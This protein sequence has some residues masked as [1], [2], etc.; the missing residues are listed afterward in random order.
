MQPL[1]FPKVRIWYLITLTGIS[2]I[3]VAMTPVGPEEVASL[4]VIIL[5]LIF[6]I[7]T[8][9]EK[10]ITTSEAR[11]K[12][13]ET[14]FV[15]V[16]LKA[17][18][19]RLEKRGEIYLDSEVDFNDPNNFATVINR[20]GADEYRRMGIADPAEHFRG[21]RIRVRGTVSVKDNVP[22]IEVKDP[23]QIEIVTEN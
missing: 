6:S 8:T 16:I 5:G 22:R 21:K 20:E 3:C 1:I 10:P 18:K 13:N 17:T 19:N 7:A 23:K 14:V 4:L 9:I 15:E 2:V 12:V 11:K